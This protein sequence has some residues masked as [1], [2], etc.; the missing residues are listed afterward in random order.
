MDSLPEG[1]NKVRD[2]RRSGGMVN[3]ADGILNVE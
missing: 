2:I 3:K 1:E